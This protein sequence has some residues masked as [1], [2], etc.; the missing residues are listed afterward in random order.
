VCTYIS[1]KS[2]GSLIVCSYDPGAAGDD[3]AKT[4]IPGG[5]RKI[6]EPVGNLLNPN[7]NPIITRL[8][9]AGNAKLCS[10][11]FRALRADRPCFPESLTRNLYRKKIPEITLNVP[12]VPPQSFHHPVATLSDFQIAKTWITK[13]PQPPVHQRSAPIPSTK[14]HLRK[15][16]FSHDSLPQIFSKTI[17]PE[18][19]PGLSQ[20]I[21]PTNAM[22]ARF[23][24]F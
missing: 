9:I 5:I 11:L 21:F 24:I 7:L 23:A 6:P 17:S 16:L 14:F 15:F 4:K 20:K 3:P 19:F 12:H 10:S 8:K 13:T 18:I 22:I 1:K 2:C